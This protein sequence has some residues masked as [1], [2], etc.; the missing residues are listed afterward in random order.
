LIVNSLCNVGLILSYEGQHLEA[1]RVF[2]DA[3][4]EAK[5]AEGSRTLAVAY[6]N[7]GCGAALAGRRD[8]SLQLLE[9]AISLGLDP[10]AY[11]FSRQDD[12]K[13]LRGDPGFEALA[14]RLRSSTS[15]SAK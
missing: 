10:G 12:L 4:A 14:A 6:F 8:Q 9:R 11:D 5:R 13:S 15:A 1:E 2:Q 3:V 7:Y